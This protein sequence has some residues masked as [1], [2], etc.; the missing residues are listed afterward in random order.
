[1]AVATITALSAAVLHARMAF[2]PDDVGLHCPV[3]A[4]SGGCAFLLAP[5][6]AHCGRPPC[7]VRADYRVT[8]PRRQLNRATFSSSVNAAMA[9]SA[10]MRRG[11]AGFGGT[12]RTVAGWIGGM[13]AARGAIAVAGSNIGTGGAAATNRGGGGGSA[14]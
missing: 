8:T 14:G 13:G 12:A 1:M 3:A 10:S 4:W 7:A 6:N 2:L 5:A 9:A 11:G